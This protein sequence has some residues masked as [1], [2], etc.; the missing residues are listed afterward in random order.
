MESNFSFPSEIKTEIKRNY[1]A[2]LQR[3]RE[4]LL[5]LHPLTPENGSNRKI[6]FIFK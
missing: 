4:I 2:Q 5:K 1:Y 3:S 6:L